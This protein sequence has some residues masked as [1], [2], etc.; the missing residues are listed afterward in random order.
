MHNPKQETKLN[1]SCDPAGTV[2]NNGEN[3]L[4]GKNRRI[5]R[6]CCGKSVE[7]NKE[8]VKLRRLWQFERSNLLTDSNTSAFVDV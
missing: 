6:M 8:K 3:F 2:P 5:D 4:C 1:F 7:K